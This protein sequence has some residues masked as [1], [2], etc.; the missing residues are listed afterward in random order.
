LTRYSSRRDPHKIAIAKLK[1]P[2]NLPNKNNPEAD[3]IIKKKRAQLK[4]QINSIISS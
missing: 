4:P 3:L 2:I 1:N